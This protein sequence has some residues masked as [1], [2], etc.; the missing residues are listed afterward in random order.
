MALA[1]GWLFISADYRL[2]Y[3]STLI[4]VVAD[5]KALFAFLAD[6]DS[7]EAT[8]EA[9]HSFLPGV[10]IDLARI[11]VAGGSAGAYPARAAA[12]YE[13]PRPAALLSLF[14]L[15]G[16]VLAD[17]WVF[18]CNAQTSSGGEPEALDHV[19]P[20]PIAEAPVTLRPDGTMADEFG[21][22]PLLGSWWTRGEMLDY[23]LGEKG[24]G[25]ELKAL[26]PAERLAALPERARPAVLDAWVDGAFPPTFLVHGDADV[27]VPI[28][29]SEVTFERLRELGVRTELVR[30]LGG[31]HGLMTETVPP[32]VMPEALEAYARGMD[33]IEEEMRKRLRGAFVEQMANSHPYECK[34]EQ[35]D[36]RRRES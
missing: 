33:F 32:R 4:D 25:A 17:R 11:A 15:G 36:A 8:S 29:E 7:S 22:L 19:P 21:R 26:P 20:A 31:T 14:G 1:R 28:E 3:P 35:Q 6:S 18:P 2:V 30:V 16:A 9:T 24:V 23:L 12:L 13:R 5:V 27:A 10:K 34:F